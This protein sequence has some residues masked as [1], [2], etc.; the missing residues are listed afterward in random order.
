[1]DGWMGGLNNTCTYSNNEDT[2][3]S[4]HNELSKLKSELSK[5]STALIT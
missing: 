4:A 1:M 5:Y 2:G 3:E